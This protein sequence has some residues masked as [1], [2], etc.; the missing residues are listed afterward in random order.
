MVAT[1][2]EDTTPNLELLAQVIQNG[3]K[4][5]K[6]SQLAQNIC[7]YITCFLIDIHSFTVRSHTVTVQ[8]TTP[9]PS[10]VKR[11]GMQM[12]M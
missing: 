5:F 12:L 10:G 4:L 2:H 11:L 8:E 7:G 9:A 1:S 6:C 3:T